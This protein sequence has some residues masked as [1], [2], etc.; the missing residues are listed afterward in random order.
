MTTHKFIH[1]EVIYKKEKYAYYRP[2]QARKIP[3]KYRSNRGFMPSLKPHLNNLVL[4]Y[5]SV[6]ERDFLILLDQDPNCVDLQPQPVAIPYTTVK[7]KEVIL[8]PD[9]W[10][11]F[12]NG[13][14]FLFEIK[15]E[16]E[17]SKLIEDEN[18]N[19][20]IKAI[21]EYCKKKGW[22]YQVITELKINCVRLNII[23]DLIIGAK[24]YSPTK[25]NKKIGSFYLHI[26]KFLESPKKFQMLPKLLKPFVPLEIEEIISLL[27]FNI[28]YQNIHIDWSKPLEEAEV[29]SSEIIPLI[30]IYELPE[31]PQTPILNTLV[32][33]ELDNKTIIRRKNEE[34][35]FQER[36]ELIKPLFDKFGN[37][38]KKSDVEKYCQENNKPFHRTYKYYLLYKKNGEEALY[39]NWSKKH[40]KSHLDARVEEELQK[41]LYNYNHGK[42]VQISGAYEEFAKEC[43]KKGLK[44]ASQKTFYNRVNALPASESQGKYKPK[45]QLFI[46]R[47]FSSTYREGRYPGCVIQMDHTPLDIWLR[48]PLTKQPFGR[49]HLTLG[50][51]VYSRSIWS[52][53]LSFNNPSRE[54]VLHT[55]IR[56]LIPKNILPDWK[57]FESEKIKTG[58]DPSQYELPCTGFP[59]MLQVDNGMDFRAKE[60]KKF[61]MKNN[62]TLEFRPVKTPEYGGFVESIW[63]TINDE[64]RNQKLPGRVFSQQKTRQSVSRPKF[65][66]PPG[67]DAKE[68]CKKRGLTLEDFR[69]WLFNYFVIKY[70]ADIRA[71][72]NHAPNELWVDGLRGD[73]YHPLG[74]ALRII[75]IEEYELYDYEAK[76]EV[77]PT[78]SERGLRYENIY[79][80]SKWL[81]KAR[82]NKILI[83]KKKYEFKIS[84][85]DIRHAYMKNPNTGEIEVLEAYNY[86]KDDRGLEFLLRGLGKKPGYKPFPI[87]LNDIKLLEKEL[88]TTKYDDNERS[89]ILDNMSKK[90]IVKAEQNKKEIREWE[91]LKKTKEG[92]REIEKQM[93]LAQM[94]ENSIPAYTEK[95]LEQIKVV[96]NPEISDIEP[97]QDD[98]KDAIPY[99]TNW[100]DVKK[101]MTLSIFYDEENEKE[102]DN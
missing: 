96:Q 34:Q 78:L 39:P 57:V 95:E 92:K 37:D 90:M 31:N 64:I 25:I 51:D 68:D 65:K 81:R 36:L 86:T 22:T 56:G 30:S 71:K 28:Y 80:S 29:S 27:K 83:D 12:T 89:A 13:R 99:A 88:G 45:T 41:A 3:L 16:H 59:S 44:P 60:V 8:Y 85:W 84:H 9:C 73:K 94:D 82:K 42:W 1:I 52:Y 48:D 47:G 58:F 32:K 93:K 63:D 79:Y 14:E 7:G 97:E 17:Y 26:E 20:R 10:A 75:D 77:E 53:F 50:V 70:S 55:I 11:Y 66:R 102:D 2:I 6:L 15:S 61:C 54:T 43:K 21:Q 5:E 46:A 72:Q 98:D 76:K 33:P 91:K 100:E 40:T 69:E 87:S 35:R 74:G 62:I 19:L 38:G 4:E 24:H 101:H 49:P 67:Y 18:W 23:K